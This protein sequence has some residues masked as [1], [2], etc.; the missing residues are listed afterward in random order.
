MTEKE[1]AINNI[2]KG[3]ALIAIGCKS[4]VF[5]CTEC[6]FKEYCFQLKRGDAPSIWKPQIYHKTD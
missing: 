1:N 2:K 5:K 4:S 6:P 3:M